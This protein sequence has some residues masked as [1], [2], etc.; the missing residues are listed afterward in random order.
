MANDY[1]HSFL[2]ENHTNV[3]RILYQTN[4]DAL[5]A[6][7]SREIEAVVGNFPALTYFIDKHLITGLKVVGLPDEMTKDGYLA[8]RK[9]WPQF[10]AILNK[11]FASISQ[12]DHQAIRGKWLGL[13]PVADNIPQLLFSLK[14]KSWLAQKKQVHVW[15]TDLPP[16]MI[17]KKG[18]EPEGIAIDYLNV[19]AERTGIKFSYEITDKPFIEL[20]ENLKHKQHIDFVPIIVS[21]PERQE[22]MSFSHNY[23]ESPTVIA[24]RANGHSISTIQELTGKSVGVLK[25]SNVHKLLSVQ[26]P[27]IKLVLYDSNELA[28]DAL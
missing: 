21:R 16:Y 13:Y 26:Y 24:V 5:Y 4:E 8:I 23:I 10:T 18:L 12:L 9:D 27:N 22:Y 28:L 20:L 17:I 7:V 6:L 1:A 25:A 19:I 15:V 14:Q 2:K 3:E 11:T